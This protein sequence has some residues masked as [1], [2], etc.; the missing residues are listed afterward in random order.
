MGAY[1]NPSPGRPGT[2]G[3]LGLIIDILLASDSLKFFLN[4]FNFN[5]DKINRIIKEFGQW[6]SEMWVS[7]ASEKA[8]KART[9]PILLCRLGTRFGSNVTQNWD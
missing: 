6:H 5:Y 3:L 9:K 7:P 1:E 4:N 2:I 8:E